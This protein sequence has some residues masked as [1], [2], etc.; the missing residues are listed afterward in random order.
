LYY[1]DPSGN[2]PWCIA[3]VIGGASGAGF[4]LLYQL[5]MNGGNYQCIDWP[6][7]GYSAFSGAAL[8]TL[9]PTGAFLGRGGPMAI[10]YGYSS[11]P[12]LL[13]RTAIR[14][15]W[16]GPVG[17]GNMDVLSLRIGKAHF[18]FDWLLGGIRSGA[19]PIRDG[20]LAGL[21]GTYINSG[22]GGSCGCAK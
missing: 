2:C 11:T 13:N 6:S 8:S 12:G 15:G 22:N 21:I 5:L 14:F 20:G 19:D 1:T 17:M 16:S 10:P 3:L 4:D 7:V 18:D 9:G